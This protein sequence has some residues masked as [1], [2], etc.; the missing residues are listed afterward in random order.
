MLLTP[1][2]VSQA[3]G[4]WQELPTQSH[5][6]PVAL[7]M[8]QHYAHDKVAS[9]GY[10]KGLLLSAVQKAQQAC[11]GEKIVWQTFRKCGITWQ[12]LVPSEFQE[13]R[14]RDA[15]ASLD[16]SSSESSSSS[17]SN[18]SDASAA[19]RVCQTINW[20]SVQPAVVHILQDGG[21]AFI[22]WC[23]TTPFVSA[24]V[25]W[26]TGL[27]PGSNVCAKCIHR[28]PPSLLQAIRKALAQ[29]DG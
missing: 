16:E 15:S 6:D 2:F 5:V 14:G 13:V 17:S 22:P 25:K 4:N 7:S 10:V 1:P 26:G 20:M 29:T 8:A 12:S 11:P 19:R 23:R 27:Q 21:A 28:V 3:L 24:N 18:A 9:A